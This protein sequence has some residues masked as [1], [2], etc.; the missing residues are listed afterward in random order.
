MDLCGQSHGFYV[1]EPGLL[2]SLRMMSRHLVR[3][4]SCSAR[5]K[6]ARIFSRTR[7]V[8]GA[9]LTNTRWRLNCET[10]L[11]ADICHGVLLMPESSV[12]VDTIS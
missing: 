8:S 5:G 7:S 3:R 10:S 1:K 11:E 4:I 2:Q 6:G 9:M 12:V